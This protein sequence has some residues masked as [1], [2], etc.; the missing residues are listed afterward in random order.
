M[1]R[2]ISRTVASMSQNGVAT[3]GS[4]RRLSAD[5]HSS[6]KSLYA[7]TQSNFSSSSFSRKKCSLPNPPT[8]GYRTCAQIPAP[9]M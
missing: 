2:S 5:A 7:E 3:I 1:H 9:S 6:R 8:L 4:S